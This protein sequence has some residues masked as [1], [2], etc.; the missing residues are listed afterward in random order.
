MLNGLFFGTQDKSS[1]IVCWCSSFETQVCN[2]QKQQLLLL[3]RRR[4]S[5]RQIYLSQLVSYLKVCTGLR[6]I[7][8]FFGDL[9]IASSCSTYIFQLQLILIL[10]YQWKLQTTVLFSFIQT[11]LWLFLFVRQGLWKCYDWCNAWLCTKLFQTTHTIVCSSKSISGFTRGQF[12]KVGTQLS[13]ALVTE[14]TL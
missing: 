14:N 10:Q 9:W 1:F 3:K 5:K 13:C 11:F 8:S 4:S 7:C 6:R 2:Q 12:K